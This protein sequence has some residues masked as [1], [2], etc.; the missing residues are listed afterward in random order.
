MENNIDM[1]IMKKGQI[2]GKQN[3]QGTEEGW[4]DKK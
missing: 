3:S 2:R 4:T 1:E